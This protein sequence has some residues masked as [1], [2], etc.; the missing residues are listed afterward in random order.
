[1]LSSPNT[2]SYAAAISSWVG[3]S[4][5]RVCRT[6]PRL[7]VEGGGGIGASY[8]EDGYSDS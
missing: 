7:I 3:I 6:M 1:M 4:S 5:S 8:L 2:V